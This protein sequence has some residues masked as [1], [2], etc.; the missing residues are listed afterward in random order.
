MRGKWGLLKVEFPN[1]KAALWRLLFSEA[2][3][4]F[5]PVLRVLQTHALPLGHVAGYMFRLIGKGNLEGKPFA[6]SQRGN[7]SGRRDSNS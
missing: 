7:L 5:E 1:Q 2:T 6:T 4:G 3:T